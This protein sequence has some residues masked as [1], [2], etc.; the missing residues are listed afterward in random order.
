MVDAEWNRIP[1]RYVHVVLNEY[2]IKPNHMH[3]ILQ[4]IYQENGRE[5]PFE[6]GS[7]GRG[8]ACPAS[9]EGP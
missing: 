2:Q 4:I 1:E 5:K 8:L 6:N 7:V 9:T 3:G